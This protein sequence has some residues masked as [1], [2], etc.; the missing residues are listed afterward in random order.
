MKSIQST[1][2]MVG[3]NR[4]GG[5]F[6]DLD[7]KRQVQTLIDEFGQTH[8]KRNKRASYKT[9]KARAYVAHSVVS[10]LREA[11]YMIKNIMNIDQR[12]ITVVT[13]RWLERGLSASTMQ[14]RFSILRWLA[15]AIGK[16]GLVRD[17]SFYSVPDSAM[18]RTYAAVVDKSW[19]GNGVD[20]HEVIEAA[21]KADEWVSTQLEAMDAY[22]LRMAEAILLQPALARTGNV[23]RIEQGTKGGRTRLVPI[24]T[25]YQEQVLQRAADLAKRSARGNLV[26]PGKNVQQAKDRLYYIVRRKLRISKAASG[27]TPHGLRHQYANDRYEELS[28]QPSVVR[29]GSI[30]DR[31]VD[32]AARQAVSNELGHS[33]LG[34]TA[35]YTGPRPKGRPASDPRPGLETRLPHSDEEETE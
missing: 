10:E 29:G 26:P 20:S 19:S 17:P 22:G 11:G 33:R 21:A 8:L 15:A 31:A 25:E 4:F 32:Q 28:G 1:G 34:V 30:V 2:A 23:L 12:H 5:R 7:I 18:R 9:A 14:T 24:E 27:V 13:G 35:S 16:A 6:D 3:Q